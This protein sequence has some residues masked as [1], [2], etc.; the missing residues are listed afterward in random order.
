MKLVELRGM[1]QRLIDGHSARSLRVD[2][3]QRGIATSS[4]KPWTNS[5]ITEVLRNPR[6]VGKRTYKGEIVADAEW[7]PIFDQQTWRKATGLAEPART[8]MA[9]RTTKAL[10]HP[11]SSLW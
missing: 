8:E 4:G 5:R 9:R 7:P 3:N 6:Y 2:L 1:A 11:S 10:A